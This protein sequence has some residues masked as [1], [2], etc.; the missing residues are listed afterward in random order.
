MGN[1]DWIELNRDAETGIETIAPIS[2]ATP[3]IRTS[4]TAT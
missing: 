4:T 2:K 3:T 1:N